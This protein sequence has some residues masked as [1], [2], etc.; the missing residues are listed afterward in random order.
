MQRQRQPEQIFTFRLIELN[1]EAK[2]L[3]FDAI[4]K[5]PPLNFLRN[6]SYISEFL[7]YNL[8]IY[9]FNVKHTLC[10]VFVIKLI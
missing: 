5:G 7:H 1:G 8:L 10:F 2:E 9:F 6:F 4:I 3:L